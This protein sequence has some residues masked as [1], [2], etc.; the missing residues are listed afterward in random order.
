MKDRPIKMELLTVPKEK[1]QT[2]CFMFDWNEE[3][4]TKPS[5]SFETVAYTGE[6]HTSLHPLG[7]KY[8]FGIRPRTPEE[9]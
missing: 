4:G 2:E 6:R 7:N 9:D 1:K 5:S 8:V 3:I